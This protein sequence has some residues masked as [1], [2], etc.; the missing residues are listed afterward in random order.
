MRT[1]VLP[2]IV[3]A[4]RALTIACLLVAERRIKRLQK[5]KKKGPWTTKDANLLRLALIDKQLLD[6]VSNPLFDPYSVQS[7]AAISALLGTPHPAPAP[8]PLLRTRSV[9]PSPGLTRRRRA[10]QM[11]TLSRARRTMVCAPPPPPTP[12][13]ARTSQRRSSA[14]SLH[15]PKHAHTKR[16]PRRADCRPSLDCA[17]GDG[18]D[19]GPP[20]DEPGARARPTRST[21]A[22]TAAAKTTASTSSARPPS[23]PR[24]ASRCPTGKKTPMM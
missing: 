4:H 13:V 8:V 3:A 11:T 19:P 17:G 5:Q 20:P 2:S 6:N 16:A 10:A 23:G 12:A 15:E 7:F 22:A 14:S 9:R 1:R 24:W 18:G 21:T